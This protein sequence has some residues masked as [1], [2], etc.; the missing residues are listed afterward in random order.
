MPYF[1]WVGVDITGT[2]RKGKK[3]ASSLED[4]SARLLANG[5]ALLSS[6]SLFTVS[7]LWPINAKIKSDVFKQKAKLLRAGVLLPNAL[8]VIAQQ[9]NNPILYDIFL[10]MWHDVQHGIFFG[11]ALEKYPIFHDPIVAIMLT[12]GYESGNMISSIENVSLYYHKQHVFNKNIR[13][14][15]AMPLLTLLFFIGISFFI[16]VF[17]IPRF[18]DMFSSLQQELPALTRSMIAISNFM[19][20]SSMVYCIIGAIITIVCMHYYFVTQSGKKKWNS[21]INGMPFIGTIIWQ[22]HMCQAL[23]AL[24]L[25]V[26][27]GVS[28]VAALEIVSE[29]VEHEAIKR[30]L[31]SLHNDVSSG[32]LLSVAMT[33][34][35]LFLPEITA[36]IFVGQESGS[37]G[38]SL[39]S[40]ALVYNDTVEARL[41]RFIFFLQPCVIIL[42]GLL[43]MTLIFAVYAPI[44]QLSQVI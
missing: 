34:T 26:A 24:G 10:G 29:S 39:E 37:L 21:I 33:T 32:L 23:Q 44:M 41:Q 40:A 42:L 2:I 20:S 9:S 14:A 27:S 43:V 4:L 38:Q 8:D 11:K 13:A 25:L 12:A 22:Y 7:C 30:L 16:F 31:Q 3:P 1:K 35:G 17:I 18:A 36:L 19:Y 6:Q 5:I 15:L 28:L